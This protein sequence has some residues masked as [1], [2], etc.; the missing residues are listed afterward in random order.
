MNTAQIIMATHAG[1]VSNEYPGY[2]VLPI[3]EVYSISRKKFLDKVLRKRDPKNPNSKYDVMINLNVGGN[4]RAVALHRMLASAFIPN[5]KNKNTVNHIDG[6][7]ANNSLDNLEWMTQTENTKHAHRLGLV[8]GRYT[9][10]SVSKLRYRETSFMTFPSSAEAAAFINRNGTNISHANISMVAAKNRKT[11]PNTDEVPHTSCGYVWR[12]EP[13]LPKPKVVSIPMTYTSDDIDKLAFVEFPGNGRY[14]VTKDGRIYDSQVSMFV[15]G[16]IVTPYGKGRSPYQTHYI[17]AT[18]ASTTKTTLRTAK[19]VAET[20][21]IA[22]TTIAH[23]D[24]NSSNCA[25]TNLVGCAPVTTA[26]PVTAYTLGWKEVEV[27]IYPSIKELAAATGI[28]TQVVYDS[29]YNNASMLS[30]TEFTNV[31]RPRLTTDGYVIRGLS[32]N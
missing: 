17:Y 30:S 8:S 22:G 27:I 10:C 28:S 2:I 26:K 9:S 29:V 5:T 32:K 1:R 15:P 12:L 16:S 11:A 6:N 7:P 4:G 23:I 24:N 18:P 31:Q 20:Y 19:V 13:E 21:G 25:V 3:G 14:L